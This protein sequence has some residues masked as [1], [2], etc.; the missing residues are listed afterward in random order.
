MA[1]DSREAAGTT[2]G[3]DL[4]DRR[5]DLCVLDQA[6]EVVRR[7]KAATT[8]AGLS[9]ALARYPGARVVLEVGTH[10]PWV[11]RLVTRQG[12][13]AVVANPWRV[14]RIAA[15]EDKSDR[16]DAE[17]LARLGRADPK[18]LRPIEHRGEQAQKDRSLLRVRDGMVRAR[19]G[20]VT[21]ARQI[22]KSL[23][24]RLPKCDADDFSR[25][26][27][28]DGLV[29]EFPGLGTLRRAV[30]ELTRDIAALDREIETACVERYPETVRLRGIKG[31]G[32]IT[33]LAFVLT[34]DDPKRFERSRDVGAYLGLRPKRWQ[35]GG[36]D[37]EMRISKA[38]DRYTRQMLVQASHYILG[39]FGP[40]TAL[41]RFGKRLMA[42]GG[43]SARKRAVVAVARKLA[44]LMHRL[45]VTGRQYE[46]L[47]G[48]RLDVA[49]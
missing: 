34:I 46:P 5:S 20:L 38:G 40:D 4:G 26:L 32:P 30:E 31:V 44:V 39:H 1:R 24:K 11:S 43:R 16:I 3:L 14:R 13:Q 29:E 41:R 28:K 49:A 19:S 2:I 21:R 48:V 22:T 27:E 6:G 23:G 33:A 42:R 17:L 47:H 25:R 9:K 8:E 12:C 36:S 37:P 35:S 10:S 45:W 7:M 18:L 15:M